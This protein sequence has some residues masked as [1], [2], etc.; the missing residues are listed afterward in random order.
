M[1]KIP[2]KMLP[3]SWGLKGKS[4][5]MAEANYLYEGE[6]LDRKLAKIEYN[7]NDLKKENLKIDLKY[8]KISELECEKQCKTIDKEPWVGVIDSKFDKAFGANG[9]Y[10]ELDWNKEFIG[11]LNDAGYTGVDDVDIVKNWFNDICNYSSTEENI[12]LSSQVTSSPSLDSPG[13]TMIET[14][15]TSSG[16]KTVYS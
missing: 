1:K 15:K 12:T 16:N 10:F 8:E 5:K 11:V 13:A 7:G 4:Y 6:E 9:L 3:V 2:F 14:I